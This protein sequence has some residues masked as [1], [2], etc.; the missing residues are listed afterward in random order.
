MV[1]GGYYRNPCQR[2]DI[3]YLPIRDA[4]PVEWDFSWRVARETARVRAFN[5]AP[6]KVSKSR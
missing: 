4:P 1:F 5:E 6:L 3:R 2:P